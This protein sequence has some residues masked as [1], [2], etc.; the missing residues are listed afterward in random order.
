MG[1][2]WTKG[3]CKMERH[4][5]SLDDEQRH[6]HEPLGWLA[7]GFIERV[8]NTA[9]GADGTPFRVCR[10]RAPLDVNGV[11]ADTKKV[12]RKG[13]SVDEGQGPTVPLGD[14]TEHDRGFYESGSSGNSPGRSGE[15]MEHCR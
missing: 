7:S 1:E 11:Q 10:Q 8:K 15:P 14:H 2:R 4:E 9:R 3:S 5:Y 13:Q 6:T 12:R